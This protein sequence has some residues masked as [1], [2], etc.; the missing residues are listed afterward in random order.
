MSYFL[1]GIFLNC[2]TFELAL[3]AEGD[4]ES[5]SILKDIFDKNSM[6]NTSFLIVTS[7]K[8]VYLEIFRILIA[9]PD[10]YNDH[11]VIM[12]VVANFDLNSTTNR[13]DF[14][15]STLA[16]YSSQRDWF[17]KVF[18]Y[19]VS[20]DGIKIT[21][22]DESTSGITGNTYIYRNY[23]NDYACW[24]PTEK[25]WLIAN[26]RI[27]NFIK[28]MRLLIICKTTN[29]PITERLSPKTNFII[30]RKI[31][32]EPRNWDGYPMTT[33][34]DNMVVYIPIGDD[35]RHRCCAMAKVASENGLSLTSCD[36]KGC[37]ANLGDFFVFWKRFY[38]NG[39]LKF[40]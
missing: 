21:Y 25:R 10:D 22:I 15:Y 32:T 8:E 13:I 5:L 9:R 16:M 38:V 33:T 4:L 34:L 30:L 31:H 37:P 26:V 24:R 3:F 35:G 6:I 39:F 12:D 36:N 1:V 14:D 23:I 2:D 40:G 28:F 17:R 20:I 18:G 29:I 7:K 19:Y 11:K 27:D